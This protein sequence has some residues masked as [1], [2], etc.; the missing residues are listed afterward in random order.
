MA[1]RKTLL[2][3][4]DE[5]EPQ[6][7]NAFLASI[8]NIKD[9]VRLSDVEAAIRRGDIEAAIDA[10]NIRAEY[11]A[12]LDRAL[13]TAYQDGGDFALAALVA[14]AKSQ[15]ARVVG[16]FDVRN[17]QAERFTSTRAAQLITEVV[18][19]TKQQVREVL[20]MGMRSGT[21]PRSAAL[22]I[23]G[24]SATRGQPRMGG[25]IGLDSRRAS[26]VQEVR[27]I[28]SSPERIGE[29]F[30]KDRETG[31]LKPRFKKTDRAFDGAVRRAIADGKPMPAAQIKRISDRHSN[32][33]LRDRGETIARTELLGSLHHAQ[34][35]ALRQMM[36]REG[37]SQD[38]VTRTW[39]SAEDS[40]TRD[41]HRDADG[42]SRKAGEPFLV[43]GHMML[44][45]GDRSLGAPGSEIIQCRCVLKTSVDWI[46]QLRPDD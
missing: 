37:L 19:G 46:S 21:S 26:Q 3:L 44:H 27:D 11:M 45:P 23:V 6:V 10:L 1:R 40:A 4:L 5:L 8:Q 25:I 7:R 12:P 32:R 20:T 9:D 29:Y 14:D 38:A 15:G 33:L 42:Q 41:S 35:E 31:K 43:G 36:A 17:P 28:L 18:E 39:D 13:T 16:R 34:D 30:I 2:D 24:R 22:D